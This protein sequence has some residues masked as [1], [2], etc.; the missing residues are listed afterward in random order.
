MIFT[1]RPIIARRPPCS[2]LA[3]AAILASCALNARQSR[4]AAVAILAAFTWRSFRSLFTSLALLALGA[5]LTGRTLATRPW[6][7]PVE[8]RLGQCAGQ[9]LCA[10]VA[11]LAV[12]A[13][14]ALNTRWTLRTGWA[15]GVCL[16]FCEKSK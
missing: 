1:N 15:V 9:P 10:A 3:H 2:I 4:T 11:V 12:Q 8:R 14:V 7:V 13:V 6:L 5:R 16:A